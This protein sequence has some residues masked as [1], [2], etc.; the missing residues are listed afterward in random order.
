VNYQKR[1][2]LQPILDDIEPGWTIFKPSADNDV[3]TA[4]IFQ[5]IHDYR[6]AEVEI[7]NEYLST[8]DFEEI[9]RLV[10]WAIANAR[11]V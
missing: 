9:E 3:E 10:K 5:H 8:N 6:Q 2:I 4:C 1:E 11:R 7:P